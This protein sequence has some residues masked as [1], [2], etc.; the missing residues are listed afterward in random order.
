MTAPPVTKRVLALQYAGR[1]IDK[2]HNVVIQIPE[3]LVECEEGINNVLHIVDNFYGFDHN[4]SAVD[5]F[6]KF[7]SIERKDDQSITEFLLEFDTLY[8]KNKKNGNILADYLLAYLFIEACNMTQ[9]TKRIGIPTNIN[10]TYKN[11]KE[12]LKRIFLFETIKPAT[13]IISK[14]VSNITNVKKK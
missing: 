12:T 9:I 4:K 7:M 2:L 8:N 5:C 11:V 10:L 13:S 14:S 1:N 3:D 6:N